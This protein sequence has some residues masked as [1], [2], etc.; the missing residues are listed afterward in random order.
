M[1]GEAF[2][3]DL[4]NLRLKPSRRLDLHA[5]YT[6]TPHV[7]VYADLDNAFDDR[8]QIAHAGDGTLSYDN[9][10]MLS[11]GIRFTD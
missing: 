4:N 6:V 1:D 7:M 3:D 11:I 2:E 10:R 8:I 5:D 9:R